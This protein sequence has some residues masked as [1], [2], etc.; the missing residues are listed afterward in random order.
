MHRLL[1][2]GLILLIVA[3]VALVVRQRQRLQAYRVEAARLQAKWGALQVDVPEKIYLRA[4]QT[5]DP[6]HFAWR[7][8]LPG[9]TTYSLVNRLA[10]GYTSASIQATDPVEFLARCHLRIGDDGLE[11]FVDVHASGQGGHRSVRQNNFGELAELIT[12]TDQPLSIELLGAGKAVMLE[13]D[14]PATLLQI[15]ASESL[16]EAIVQQDDRRLDQYL[17][18]PLYAFLVADEDAY[19]RIQQESAK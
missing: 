14:Q 6:L 4:V 17:D 7:L 8:H 9:G 19:R 12:A 2:T 1:Q 18:E 16:R 10:N 13:P 15:R 11:T 5:D 3:G